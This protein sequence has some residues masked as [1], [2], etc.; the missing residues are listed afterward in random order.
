MDAGN[1]SLRRSASADL[2]VIEAIRRHFRRSG[3]APSLSEISNDSGV[4][5]TEVG[6]SLRRLQHQGLLEVQPGVPRGSMLTDRAAN[7]SDLELEL[8]VISRGGRIEWQR[9]KAAPLAKAYT[10]VP[11]GTN[12]EHDLAALLDQI[13]HAAGSERHGE[14]EEAAGAAN[15]GAAAGE[16]D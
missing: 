2:R 8:A 5:R 14:S 13:D 3:A 16:G 7:L 4:R 1:L 9:V 10:P 12:C 11:I 15:D 6:R